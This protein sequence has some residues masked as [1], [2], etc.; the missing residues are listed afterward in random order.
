MKSL[1]KNVPDK[2]R[3][4]GVNLKVEMSLV[5]P[6]NKSKYQCGYKN[7]LEI[8]MGARTGKAHRPGKAFGFFYYLQYQSIE[9]FKARKY[10]DLIYTLIEKSSLAGMWT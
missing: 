2:N 8:E 9:V 7:D 4:I 5:C 3:S 6:K 1:V 10:K